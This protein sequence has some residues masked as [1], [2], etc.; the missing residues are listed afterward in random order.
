MR[1][2]HRLK[3]IL[4]ATFWVHELTPTQAIA[5]A[6]HIECRRKDPSRIEIVEYRDGTFASVIAYVGSDREKALAFIRANT[7]YGP[8]DAWHWAVYSEPVDAPL[9][10]CADDL[11]NLC[12]YDRNGNALEEQPYYACGDS[13]GD[14]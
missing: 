1:P 14:A 13:H 7:D 4:R 3:K 2:W 5:T 12:Y 6:N 11:D 9:D 8:A 10:H